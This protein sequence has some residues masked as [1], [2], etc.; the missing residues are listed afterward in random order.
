MSAVMKSD[1]QSSIIIESTNIGSGTVRG[2]SC[3]ANKYP[4]EDDSTIASFLLKSEKLHV[5][6]I[7]SQNA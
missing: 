1:K 5:I 2:A 6:P 7:K 4:K 3:N